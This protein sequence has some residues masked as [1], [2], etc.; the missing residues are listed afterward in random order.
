LQVAKAANKKS[1]NSESLN[2][3]VKPLVAI[4]QVKGEGEV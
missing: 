2:D 4:E 1:S 3:E